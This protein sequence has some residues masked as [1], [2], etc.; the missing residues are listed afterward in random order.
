MQLQ[1]IK[2]PNAFKDSKH[3]HEWLDG[4]IGI[5]IGGSSHNPYNILGTKNV[6]YTRSDNT[7][8]ANDERRLIG[9]RMP[10]D[11]VAYMHRLPIVD[12][13]VD[14]VL[15]SHVIEHAP[16]P[17]QTLKEWHRVVKP[18]GLIYCVVPHRDRTFDNTR[19][20]STLDELWER[21]QTR[22][23]GDP[24][25]PENH[26][27][28]WRTKDF[29]DLVKSMGMIVADFLDVDDKVGNGFTVVIYK[30]TQKDC[31]LGELRYK[32]GDND[33]VTQ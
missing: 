2:H 5:E 12:N 20:V 10:V 30:P 23:P 31:E 14:F 1:Q 11:Y 8:F 16:D 3:A 28:V 19:D 7:P 18:G 29:I 33:Q 6:S 22:L 15:N 9:S 24:L 25:N 32:Y 17:I 26:Y 21:H 13:S 27:S 4:L